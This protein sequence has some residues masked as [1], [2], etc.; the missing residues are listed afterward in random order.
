MKPRIKEVIVVEG[1]HDSE[2]L[3]RYFDCETI[4]THGRGIKKQVI[5]EIRRAAETSGFLATS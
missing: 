5:E 2:R 1:T 3:K 4:V